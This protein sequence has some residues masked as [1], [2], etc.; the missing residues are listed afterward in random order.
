MRS[1]CLRTYCLI[2]ILT[3]LSLIDAACTPESGQRDTGGKI[4]AVT[5]LFPLYDFA[6]NVGGSQVEVTLL[7]SPGM[8]PHSFEPRPSDIV[9]LNR[10]GLFIYT[11]ASMEPWANDILKGLLNKDLVIVE[12]SRGIPGKTH[13]RAVANHR[14][15]DDRPEISDPHTWLDFSYAVKMVENIRDGFITRDPGRKEIYE[16]NAAAYID[17]LKKLD[18]RYRSSLRNCR[19]DIIISGGHFAF[20][21]MANRYGLRYISAY[22]ISPNAEPTAAELTNIM[23]QISEN[24]VRHLYHEELINPRVSE[25]LSRESGVTLLRLHAGGNI[26][27]ED[28]ERGE[29]FLSLMEKNLDLL[30]KGLQCP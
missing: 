16:K 7:L 23:K 25:I 5:T 20:S 2:L 24:D 6:K 27:K 22:G 29:T 21:R 14:P 3:F 28:F 30:K 17:E 11:S 12:S 13:P 19:K 1:R 26:T 4:L 9:K 18:D 8:E 15:H 10:A